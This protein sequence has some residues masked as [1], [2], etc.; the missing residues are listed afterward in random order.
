MQNAIAM[1]AR[2]Q[3]IPICAGLGLIIFLSASNAPQG[4]QRG[5]LWHNPVAGLAYTTQ[6]SAAPQLTGADGGFFY[7]EG[8]RVSFSIGDLDIGTA[9]AGK[10]LTLIDLNPAA[11][12]DVRNARLNNIAMLVE[13]L[14]R[15]GNN[16]NGIEISPAAH[17]VVRA[18]RAE[19]DLDMASEDFFQLLGKLVVPEV[20]KSGGFAPVVGGANK[21]SNAA[22][23]HY[24]R[25]PEMARN[26][27]RRDQAGIMR[28]TDVRIPLRDYDPI[29][30]PDAYVLGSLH[31]PVGP[32]APAHVPVVMN[33]GGYGKDRT[34]GS[35][36]NRDQFIA[37]E[38]I[39]DR[40]RS[41]NPDKLPYENHETVETFQ[42]VPKGYAVLRVDQRGIG[43]VPGKIEP[44]GEQMQQDYTDAID[45][46]GSQPWS[47][48]R[49]GTIGISYYAMSQWLMA[50][51]LPKSTHLKA[52]I[53]WEGAFDLYRDW[54]YP[55]GLLHERFIEMG[56]AK[57]ASNKCNDNPPEKVWQGW[58]DHPYYDD[59][60]W[61]SLTAD[62]SKI[63]IP[64]LSALGSDNMSIHPRGNAMAFRFGS[65]KD[66]LLRINDGSH[67]GPFYSPDGV[68]DQM[69]FFDYWLKGIDTGIMRRPRVKISMKT[70][71][72]GAYWAYAND[73]PVR[74]TRYT[75]FYL[76][77]RPEDSGFKVP[78]KMPT[79]RL[80]PS[81]DIVTAT[82]NA[83]VAVPKEAGSATYSAVI[84]PITEKFAPP[85]FTLHQPCDSFGISF[86]TPPLTETVRLA[87]YAKLVTWVSSS[88]RDMD[89]HASLRVYDEAG[90]Q[91]VYPTDPERIDKG[92]PAPIQVGRL[93]VSRR[94]L[95]TGKSTFFQPV[96]SHLAKDSKDLRPGEIVKVEVEFW[97]MTAE[98][99]KGYRI[100]LD[101][102][103]Y[104]GCGQMWPHHYG[105]YNTGTN[106]IF[107]GPGHESYI[108]LPFVSGLIAD[109]RKVA[110]SERAGK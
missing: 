4:A 58:F 27:L 82:S 46:A 97:P 15:D 84:K 36:C 35:I 62:Y 107:T 76:D 70:G 24:P 105:D 95:D 49:V 31:R 53:P 13:T 60:Y 71:D 20:Q 68:A 110:W 90:R 3:A 5:I 104:H 81:T 72:G 17:D 91:V 59:A 48:G 56:F 1:G 101:I 50:K 26:Q 88:T 54:M 61:R 78:G 25:T 99:R 30:N 65:A 52:M 42:W 47:N 74:D 41:G 38:H 80:K 102:Q 19:L 6:R 100:V 33:M 7:R 98:I 9:P 10:W 108:Q 2:R 22:G 66:K 8:D 40:Y 83:S 94:A 109:S 29:R 37:Q 86:A 34:F 55:G 85:W 28:I 57:F 21:N 75:K 16:E 39:E 79:Y 64:F 96:H 14:D 43:N 103:P 51:K 23:K 93:K 12:G 45:W 63:T 106:S 69:A 92:Q 73:F 18:H 89:I 77:A 44:L 87:G 11:A 32:N 67:I